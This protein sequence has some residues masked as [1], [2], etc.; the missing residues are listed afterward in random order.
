MAVNDVIM[1]IMGI[2]VLIGGGDC[3]IGNRFGLGEKFEDGFRCLAPMALSMTG[4]IAIAPAIARWLGPALVPA[5][6]AVGV[7]PAMFGS[8]FAID[9]GGYP[10][11]MELAGDAAVGY[12]SGLIVAS[13]L[14]VTITFAIPMSLT[15]LEEAD[16]TYFARGVM[17]GLIPIPA[18]AFVGGLMMGLPVPVIVRNLLPICV[19]AVALIIGLVKAPEKLVQIFARLGFGIRAITY[20]GLILSAFEYMT[21]MTLVK[22]MTPIL[23]A[24]QVP[25]RIAILM[26]GSLPFMTMVTKLFRRQF[27]AVGRLC[28]INSA[29]VGGLLISCV[30]TIPVY[31]SMKE[32]N[33]KGKIVV[34]AWMVSAIGVFTSHL[35]YTMSVDPAFCGPVLSAKLISAA[36]ALCLACIFQSDSGGKA[37][38]AGRTTII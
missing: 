2:G 35:G 18:G 36:L 31:R 15:L 29:A 27:A 9:M 32:M 30:T 12:F 20:V 38:D 4:I 13:M 28:G 5:C 8:L 16:Q 37:S 17:I 14:G 11:A 10:L 6:Q 22:G 21:G 19:I 7:D 26:L 25:C 23:D 1:W 34:T 33:P 24:I 3:L